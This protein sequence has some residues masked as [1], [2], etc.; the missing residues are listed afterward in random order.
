MMKYEIGD[1]IRK[2]RIKRNLSQKK[3][4]KSLG[5]GNARLSNWEKGINRPDVDYLADICRELDV[6]PSELLDVKLPH[7]SLNEKERDVIKAYRSKPEFQKA[8][9]RL[10]GVDD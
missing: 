2:Y 9:D 3:L 5:I 4:A 6:S 10:L 1:R 8:V 7:E